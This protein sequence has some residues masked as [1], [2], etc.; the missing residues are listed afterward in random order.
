[1]L[2]K[3]NRNYR[4]YK[5]INSEYT[6]LLN[7]EN[8]NPNVLTKYLEKKN[9]AFAKSRSAANDSTMAN[10]RAK[11]EFYNSVNSTMN[12]FSISAKKKFS[13]LLKLM[14]NNKFSPTPPLFENGE[15]INEPK[16]KSEIFNSFFASKSTRS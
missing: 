2:R 9:K 13:I 7:Q 1:M 5:K 4:F 14:K 3:K 12:N 11:I 16:Q 15:T 8:T 6:H 10:R